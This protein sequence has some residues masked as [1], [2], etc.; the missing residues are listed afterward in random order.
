MNEDT[1]SRPISNFLITQGKENEDELSESDS[2]YNEFDDDD[3]I[4]YDENKK[5]KKQPIIYSNEIIYNDKDWE[6][7]LDGN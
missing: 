3:D 2:D 4:I 6:T 5:K 7:D 1:K